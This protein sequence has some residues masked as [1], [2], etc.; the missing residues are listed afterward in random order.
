MSTQTSLFIISLMN[1]GCGNSF[2]NGG[3]PAPDGN[4]GCNMPC[5]GNSAEICGGSNRLDVYT[6]GVSNSSATVAKRRWAL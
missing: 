3:G 2:A 6:Y 1:S 5:K 4:I